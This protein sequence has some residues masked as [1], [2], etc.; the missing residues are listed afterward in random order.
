M[1]K[2][3][4]LI[5]INYPKTDAEL[6]GCI[7]D[8]VDIRALLVDTFHFSMED[9]KVLVDDKPPE[10]SGLSKIPSIIYTY[11]KQTLPWG[12]ARERKSIFVFLWSIFAEVSI[13]DSFVLEKLQAFRKMKLRCLPE[14]TSEQH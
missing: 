5:G 6:K 14:K 8:V 11:G 4:V 12:R 10:D 7:N 3:A 13:A 2:K 1:V 9:I